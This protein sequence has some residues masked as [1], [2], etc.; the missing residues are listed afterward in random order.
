MKIGKLTKEVRDIVV[1]GSLPDIDTDF[2]GEERARIKEYMEQRFGDTQVCSVGTYGTL[3][4]K[5]AITD[6][7]RLEGIPIPT[8]RR[9]CKIIERE[10]IEESVEALFKLACKRPELKN[11]IN[12][13]A[14][15]FNHLFLAVGQPKTSSVHACAMMIFPKEKS[16]YEWTPVKKQKDLI[17]TEW[18]GGELDEAGFLKEDI[19]GI[20]QLDKFT[21]MI[22]EIKSHTGKTID[23]Y[24]D[25]PLDDEKVF[26]YFRDGRCQNLFHFGAKGLSSYVV[27]VA[28][29]S[30]DDLIAC[31]CLYRPGPMENGYHM[32]YL[33]RRSGEEEIEYPIG[34]EDILKNSFGLL[35][36]QEHIMLLCQKLAG[37]TLQRSDDVRKAMGK[38]ILEKLKSIR[39]EFVEGYVKRYGDKGVTEE[40]ANDLWSTMEEFGKYAFNAC[41][42]GR[43]T[44]YRHCVGKR[45]YPT[46][47]EMFKIKNDPLYAKVT[48]HKELHSKY[49][50]KGY[51]CSWTLCEDGRI[52]KTQIKD[53]R[54]AGHR[55]TF[56]ITLETGQSI[57]VTDNHKF[58]TQRGKV[59]TK[60][61]VIGEDCL[62][63]SK[64]YQ[65]DNHFFTFT[66]N[67]GK[68][69]NKKIEGT[70][71]EYQGINSEKGKEGFQK[72]DT[73]YTQLK[74]NESILRSKY[75][76][77]QLC[78][79]DHERLEIHHK[80]GDHGNND[81]SNLIL[82][83]P[84]CH[85]KIHYKQFSRNK[86]GEKGLL[87]GLVKI[88]SIE[89]DR[90]EDVY[91][92]EIDDPNHNFVTKEGIVTC[93][94]H[95]ASYSINGY[96]S[97]WFKVHYPVEFWS[98]SFSRASM[99]DYPYY[100]NEIK[101]S[102][103][104]EIRPVDINYSEDVIVSDVESNSIYWALNSVTQL[105]E[106]AQKELM[107]ERRR[108]GGYFSFEEFV[109]RFNN[110]GSSVNKSVVENLI[111]SGAFDSLENIKHPT[112]RVWLLR[113]YRELKKVKVD[114]S[115]DEYSVAESKGKSG[116]SWW[117][118]LQ[119]K[120]KSG[121]GF[122]DYEALVKEYLE[123]YIDTKGLLE[124]VFV[125]SK[126]YQDEDLRKYDQNHVMVGGYLL[127]IVEKNS[128]RGLWGE[129]TIESNY[130]FLRIICFPGQWEMMKDLI[131]KSKKDIVLINGLITNNTYTNLNSLMTVDC[132]Q[133]VVLG[134]D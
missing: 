22:N 130:E 107:E 91:D 27:Q 56:K 58:P 26:E 89:P 102:G 75:D 40:Y 20:E 23:L 18:E 101:R 11:F 125:D 67:L 7:S 80:D 24:K 70:R 41:L 61:L 35:Y 55:Q 21:D 132:S 54:F 100:I 13:H 79:S 12:D 124:P 134:V 116:K 112:D 28:P 88:V 96:N 126:D 10:E 53:I 121:F 87:S 65:Q 38:K 97:M 84:S 8:V 31:I 25:I 78:G 92:V 5:S 50:N 73:S 39:S 63:V 82:I 57:V 14:E 59:E 118:L 103:N 3:K 120:K 64:G 108:N 69:E 77:C 37:F 34:A 90:I 2:P 15:M 17:T 68:V 131:L 128:K 83:C 86:I 106:A 94:S 33:K 85:K 93:N 9:I 115:K 43:E 122:F 62:F 49:K 1:P 109:D 71:F 129:L 45:F 95:A 119:Q 117:W 81:I 36:T 98:V 30:I 52:R 74:Q 133:L 111:Y 42:S 110:K 47:E 114:P 16:M 66:S 4:L 46:I 72:R 104:I 99:D 76:K 51:G 29:R 123:P 127:D 32:S 6:F 48:G 113:K 60:D 44:I 19:L 105:G